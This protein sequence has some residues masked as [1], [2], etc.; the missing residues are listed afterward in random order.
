MLSGVARSVSLWTEPGEVPGTLEDGVMRFTARR[1]PVK[2]RALDVDA[3]F[4]PAAPDAAPPRRPQPS[5]VLAIA[6]LDRARS[7]VAGAVDDDTVR[8]WDVAASATRAAVPVRAGTLSGAPSAIVRTHGSDLWLAAGHVLQRWDTQTLQLTAETTLDRPITALAP[9]ASGHVLV[10]A[11]GLCV[12]DP[13]APAGPVLASAPT[14]GYVLTILPGSFGSVHN[15]SAAGRFPS[16]ITHDM[17]RMPT[18]AHTLYSGAHALSSL[19]DVS[20]SLLAAGEYNGRGTLEFYGRPGHADAGWTNRYA[21]SRSGML[22]LAQA[23]WSDAIVYG[24][25]ADGSIRAFDIASAPAGRCFRELVPPAD[26]PADPVFVHEIVPLTARRSV[27]LVDSGLAVLDI[28][29]SPEQ[30]P[31]EAEESPQSAVDRHIG[32]VL[33]REILG[34]EVFNLR[35]F[36]VSL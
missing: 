15:A 7:L 18:V 9:D 16:I 17:R 19:L 6:A 26:G 14:P 27:A 13:R 20:G 10:A 11:G 5:G 25:S 29:A 30:P 34:A 3:A 23:P 21:A 4:A 8:V 28:A 32:E 31:A 12:V 2:F 33:R 36:L 22:C 35:R 1:S 24:G